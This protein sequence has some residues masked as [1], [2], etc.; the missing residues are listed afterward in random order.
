MK[1]LAIGKTNSDDVPIAEQLVAIDLQ[2]IDQCV[3]LSKTI[4]TACSLTT[5]ICLEV[6]QIFAIHSKK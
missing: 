4:V 1:Y 3:K 2:E 6:D 5:K